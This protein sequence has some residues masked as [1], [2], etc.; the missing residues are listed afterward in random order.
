MVQA[1]STGYDV[2]LSYSGDDRPRVRELRDA[3]EKAGV[4]AFLDERDIRFAHSITDDIQTA[5]RSSNTMLAYYS[6]S[7]PGRSACQFELHHAYLSAVRT[8]EVEKRI[9]VVNPEN[10]RT[11]HLMPVELATHRYFRP[12]KSKSELA[13]LVAAIRVATLA[14]HTPFAGIDF[15]ARATTRQT[16]PGEPTA[17]YVGRYRD[18]W[19]IHSA[20][21][22]HDHP[23]IHAVTSQPVAGLS[24]MT[25]I[26]KSALAKVYVHDFGFLYGGGTHRI[27]LTGT[28]DSPDRVRAAHTAQLVELARSVGERPPDLSRPTVLAWWN[29]RLAREGAPTLWI[30]DDIPAGLPRDV[31]T[32]LIPY[33]PGVHTLLIGQREFP[34]DIAIPVRLRAMTADD[35]H[36]L[37]T[38][39]HPAA[40]T[41]TRAVDDIVRRLG[42][43][44][45]AILLAAGS[46]RAREGLWNLGDRTGHLTT[47]ATVQAD[48]LRTVQDVIDTLSTAEK[49][50]LGL[51][52]VCS[53]TP[54]PAV[55]VADV[56]AALS[57]GTEANTVLAGMDR[58]MLVDRVDGSTSW[59]VHQL[60]RQAARRALP[61]ADLNTVAAIAAYKLIALAGAENPGLGEHAGALL[62]RTADSP[63]FANGLNLVAARDYDRRGEPALA[64][65]FHE[66]LHALDPDHVEH[67][68]AAARARRAA[69]HLDRAAAHADR[70]MALATDDLTTLRAACVRAEVLDAR[71]RHRDAAPLWTSALAN[72]LL[73]TTSPVEQIV[74][75]TAHVHNRRSLGHFTE[76]RALATALLAEF[77]GTT[78]VEA[79]IPVRLELAE[80]GLASDDRHGA[81]KA[82]QDVVDH[83]ERLGLPLHANAVEATATVQEGQFD[84]YI[85]ERLPT[86]DDWRTAEAKLRALLETARHTFGPDNPRTARIA[87]AHLRA[88]VGRGAP[89]LVVDEYSRLP[90]DLAQQLGVD[91]R[92]HLRALFLLG[93]AFAQ[94]GDHEAALTAYRRALAGQETSLGHE[95]PETLRTRYELGVTLL[96]TGDRAGGQD[97]IRAVLR[98]VGQE[99][100][101]RNELHTQAMVALG[102]SSFLPSA[103]WR[104]VDRFDKRRER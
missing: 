30:V 78:P 93:Q 25:G 98:D 43:H 18:R 94:R 56:L 7:F 79:L 16:S 58:A 34:P 71:G 100:G 24:G 12:W 11:D 44:P 23:L 83:Y 45:Y 92:L 8:G 28:D 96:T 1:R 40:A 51:A 42:G 86:E 74:V 13:E 33:A 91:H 57:P 60:V 76:A 4:R 6:A 35:G 10:P 22:R 101:K 17:A 89:S 77:A 97:A 64:A 99:V 70:L 59:Q 39:D 47:D 55:L 26:G 19:A 46:S 29:A 21:H 14:V 49:A 62:D 85:L 67:L 104:A 50:V 38:R 36:E 31:L 27:T 66:S 48:A 15:T 80:I 68:L 90:D 54:L 2:F 52:A 103:V 102:L 65:P 41:E 87:V 5:L 72:P 95:H 20:L 88:M 75:R 69:G 32:E 81:R 61:D 37:F 84:V 63:A 3:L 9:L 82:A 73:R 53:A